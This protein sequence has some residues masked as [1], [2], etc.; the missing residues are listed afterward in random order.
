MQ[1]VIKAHVQGE[2]EV[3]KILS[4]LQKQEGR[5]GELDLALISW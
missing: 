5:E 3:Q 4:G 2:V 1:A